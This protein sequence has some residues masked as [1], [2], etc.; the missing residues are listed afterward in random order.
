MIKSTVVDDE[1]V[2]LQT[3]L[4]EKKLKYRPTKRMVLTDVRKQAL[5]WWRSKESQHVR[6]KSNIS[7]EKSL[8]DICFLYRSN[9]GGFKEHL[10]TNYNLEYSHEFLDWSNVDN[11]NYPNFSQPYFSWGNISASYPLMV[12]F[13]KY[14]K[15]GKVV[16]SLM[17]YCFKPKMYCKNIIQM[18]KR[19]TDLLVDVTGELSIFYN[20]K[21]SSS[22]YSLNNFLNKF[23]ILINY[24]NDSDLDLSDTPFLEIKK[25]FGDGS[26]E[27]YRYSRNPIFYQLPLR[28]LA[29]RSI[30]ANVDLHNH[31]SVYDKKKLYPITSTNYEIDKKTIYELDKIRRNMNRWLDRGDTKRATKHFLNKIDYPP[32]IE[33]I[34][35]GMPYIFKEP[36]ELLKGLIDDLGVDISRN[37]LANVER[38]ECGIAIL[39]MVK[40]GFSCRTMLR[41]QDNQDFIACAKMLLFL[42]LVKKIPLDLLKR[43]NDTAT[44]YFLRI[45]DIGNYAKNLYRDEIIDYLT[46]NI[47]IKNTSLKSYSKGDI[48]IRPIGD[49]QEFLA[50][51]SRLKICL[52]ANEYYA[53]KWL[54]GDV[55][56][57]VLTQNG[58]YMACIE[59]TKG[60]DLVNAKMSCNTPVKYYPDPIFNNTIKEWARKCNINV[61]TLDL[62]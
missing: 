59:L 32:S 34:L 5:K 53:E 2:L 56:L 27:H 36:S 54:K 20:G 49:M 39:L 23:K 46:K 11:N 17:E 18:Y 58:K 37:V 31:F 14:K 51:G 4:F 29:R 13:K 16:L 24:L 43:N 10:I 48:Q 40:A 44:K 47:D 50:V 22:P 15:T 3:F 30:F 26:L 6:R 55:L 21:P 52:R 9:H 1:N 28:G 41:L 19:S 57:Y 35:L 61:P 42:H 62:H 7:T 33:K 8:R 25:A 45:S 12:T 60:H 38:P